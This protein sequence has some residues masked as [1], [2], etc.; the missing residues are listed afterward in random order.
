MVHSILADDGI[1]MRI[2]IYN[3]LSS[4]NTGIQVGRAFQ[5]MSALSGYCL[6]DRQKMV[7]IDKIR[8]MQVLKEINVLLHKLGLLQQ[9]VEY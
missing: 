7:W 3:P 1:Y 6:K 2:Q 4:Y 9:W 5:E 8:Y